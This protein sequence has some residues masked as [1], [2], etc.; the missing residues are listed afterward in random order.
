MFEE[1]QNLYG[2]QLLNEYQR[3]VQ[4]P[5][6]IPNMKAPEEADP[7]YTY[8]KQTI[9]MVPA[10]ITSNVYGEQEEEIS[11]VLQIINDVE[12]EYRGDSPLNNA[13]RMAIGKI[14]SEISTLKR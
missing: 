1:L 7:R 5:Q 8:K 14:K 6:M 2:K 3:G 4:T 9:G 11:N 10:N 12:S 13:V